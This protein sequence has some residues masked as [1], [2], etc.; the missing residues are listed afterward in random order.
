MIRLLIA[1]AVLASFSCSGV[2]PTPEAEFRPAPNPWREDFD[3]PASLDTKRVHLEPL[4]PEVARLDYEAFMSSR[5]HLHRTLHWNDW[6]TEDFTVAQNVQD[7]ERHWNEFEAREGYAYTVLVPDRSRCVG[8]IYMERVEGQT[9]SVRLTYWVVE[10]V[11]DE[12]L[13]NHLIESVIGWIDED[14][15]FNRVTMRLHV[16]NE[17]GIDI[18]YRLGMTRQP[19][20]DPDHWLF[21]WERKS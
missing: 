16:D 8:C 2:H 21:I 20:E 3:P 4:R 13:D 6:P 11:L 15:P 14:W 10:S 12:D 5:E 19:D 7:L 18:A 17:R 1:S 9:D